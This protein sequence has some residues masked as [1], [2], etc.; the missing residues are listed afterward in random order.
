MYILCM[1]SD[2]CG[3]VG[4]NLLFSQN[5]W[6]NSQKMQSPII[7][8]KWTSIDIYNIFAVYKCCV[9]FLHAEPNYH[10]CALSSIFR[11]AANF[12]LGNGF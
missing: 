8:V 11:G 7:I 6:K 5:G 9:T 2:L 12:Y 1:T 4:V 10:T 3:C